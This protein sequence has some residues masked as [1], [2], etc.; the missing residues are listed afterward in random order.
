LAA[1]DCSLGCGVVKSSSIHN[2]N[3]M[4]RDRAIINGALMA[5]ICNDCACLNYALLPDVEGSLM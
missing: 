2:L 4:A 5:R 1:E 3:V